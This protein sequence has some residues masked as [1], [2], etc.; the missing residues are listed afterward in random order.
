MPV[1]LD[2]WMCQ[3]RQEQRREIC[4]LS[5]DTVDALTST[6]LHFNLNLVNYYDEHC[7]GEGP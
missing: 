2:F 7:L 6:P 4:Q 1:V 5:R 3:K